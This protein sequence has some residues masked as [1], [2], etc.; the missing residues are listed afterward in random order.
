MPIAMK[1]T[2]DSAG[3]ILIPSPIRRQAGLRPGTAVEV[4]WN[5]GQ[6]EI[7]PAPVRIRLERRGRL[8]VA[9][10]E[11]EMPPLTREIV[12]A[13]RQQLYDERALDM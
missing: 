2:I 12:E 9:V 13:T 11:D 4:Q 1:S 7:A 8:L 10:P 3:R 5:D 6:I